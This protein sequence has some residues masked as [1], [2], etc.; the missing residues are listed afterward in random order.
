MEKQKNGRVWLV[1]FGAVLLSVLA[2]IPTVTASV[3]I[4]PVVTALD[5]SV[6]A[7]VLWI[8]ISAVGGTIASLIIGNLMKV[9]PAKLLVMIGGVFTGLLLV[10][11]GM[12]DNLVI[13]YCAAF[14]QGWGLIISGMTI[15]QI[16]ISKWFIKS[17][18]LMMSLCLVFIM[19]FAA[20]LNPLVAT[21][22]VSVGYQ[23]V[24]LVMG[25]TIAV[26]VIL[27][28]AFIIVDTPERVGLKPLGYTENS[29]TPGGSG[30][31]GSGGGSGG[32]G[33]KNA[34]KSSAFVVSDLPL[35]V[36]LR[37]APFW[38]IMLVQLVGT[39]AAQGIG[40]QSS[41]FFQSIG[42]DE[43]QASLAVA[44]NAL[45]G[46]VVMLLYGILTDRKGPTFAS[47]IFAIF[48]TAAFLLNFLW[49]GWTGAI[50]SAILF[51]GASAI[52]AL[53]APNM[54]VKTFGVKH[55]GQLIGYGHVAGNIGSFA[56][57][58]VVAAFFDMNNSY[59]L[60][61]TIVGVALVIITALIIWAGS[62]RTSE[63][64]RALESRVGKTGVGAPTK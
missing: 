40:S 46:M 17:R 52:S 5:T 35:K 29:E 25:I 4:M 36:I 11:F 62:K 19:V 59:T 8:S 43:V 45:V 22:I 33:E 44:I 34:K 28:G 15:A 38:V 49:M 20:I 2:V 61:F 18:G 7:V 48:A 9:I 31:S 58:I 57:P 27:I 3:F 32:S 54:L 53:Y 30:G 39:F 50:I 64:L 1:G 12:T 56:A 14:L 42:L 55:S 26:L 51:T 6:S 47:I 10:A 24:A 60:I 23:T 41:P 13:I 21:M 63:K 37:T 16:I